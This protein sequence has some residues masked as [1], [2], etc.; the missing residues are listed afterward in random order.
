MVSDAQ[1]RL[2]RQKRMERKTQEAAAAAA[3]MSVRTARTWA[4]GPL[5]SAGKTPR[6]W[7]TRPDPFA[8]VWEQEIV[9]LLTADDAGVLEATTVLDVVAER[10]GTRYGP[11][12]LRTLQ[13]RVRDWRALHGPGQEVYF[14]Q[15]HP[16][17]REGAVDFTHATEL[18]VTIA[19]TLLRHLLFQFVLSA[20]GW[21]WVAI[22][23]GETFEALVAGL[24]GALWA[25]G[26]VPAVLRSDNLSAATHEL[27]RSGGRA[28]TTRFAA[29]LDHY[30]TAPLPG[31]PAPHRPPGR[32][33]PAPG[34]GRG[35][36]PRPPGRADAPPPRPDRAPDRLP[37]RHLVAGAQARGIRPLSVPGGAVSRAHVPPGVR[38]PAR[39]AR[40]PGGRRVRAHPASGGQ[41][42]RD[43]GGAG[44]GDGARDGHALRLRGR[45][46]ARGARAPARAG[47]RPPRPG[48]PPLRS[49]AHGGAGMTPS[50]FTPP[51]AERLVALL[52]QFHLPTMATELLPRFAQAGQQEALPLLLEVCELEATDRRAR[53]IARLRAAAKLPPGKTFT[54][55]DRKRLPRPPV[56]H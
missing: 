14:E 28:L 32:G 6:S 42:A 5:P 3:G 22:A 47:A 1:V 23:F 37:P 12:Q 24:Q 39:H 40:R 44:P 26:G 45:E 18:G 48:P 35:V 7:R 17:G 52:E 21:R 10:H 13:R 15:V 55:F 29:V 33:P 20:S 30:R 16:P 8:S 56:Q 2:L 19:G 43:D 11:S 34:Q 51:M 49:P 46:G 31:P 41:H 50:A 54:T 36:L 25:L 9:P 4:R 53:R 27:K 38:R